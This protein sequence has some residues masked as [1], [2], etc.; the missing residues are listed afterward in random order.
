MRFVPSPEQQAIIDHG[1]EPLRVTAG[2][3]TGKTTTLAYR[4]VRL[5]EH[6][7]ILPGEVLGVTFTN[8]AAD[9]LAQRIRQARAGPFAPGHEVEVFTYHGF[10]AHLLGTYG[11]LVG[12]ERDTRIITPTRTRQI[13]RECLADNPFATVDITNI[14]GVVDSLIRL[15]GDLA[16]N[17][18]HP[19]DLL[20]LP[21][22]DEVEMRRAELATAL[23]AFEEA[24]LELG[25][26]DYGD[27]I[28][29][30]VE[31][32]RDHPAVAERI[33]NRYR[34][35]LLDEYQDTN[36][37]QQ[38]LFAAL[39]GRHGS[40]TAVGDLDQ[41]IYEWRG[42]SPA[43]FEGFPARF[44][45]TDGSRAR[46]LRLS[47]N[48]RSGQRIL[49]L[50]NRIRTRISAGSR[51]GR[52][53]ALPGTPPGE[54]HAA[55]YGDARHEAEEIAR[56]L[57]RLHETGVEWSD[58]A[59][60]FRRNR[61]M[62]L[63][64]QALEEHDVPLQVA[65]L[66]GLLQVPEIVELHAWLRLLADPEDSPALVRILLG[67]RYRL[68]LA[69]LV[70]LSRWVTDRTRR[71]GEP[72]SGH[73]FVE[74]LEHLDSMDLDVGTRNA[75]DGIRHLY[76]TL[77]A[78]SQGTGLSELTRMILSRTS[79]WQEI[80]SMP[81][82]SDLSARLNVHRFLD[83]TE[84]WQPLKGRSS[85]EAFLE[86]MEMLRDDPG[87]QI[88]TARI[89]DGDA[90]TLMTVH[91]AKGLEWRAVF[92]PALFRGNFPASPRRLLDPSRYEFTVPA[93]LRI[94][95]EFRA[96]LDPSTEPEARSAW[97]RARHTDQEWRLA[98]VAC[99]RAMEY[100][101]LSGAH[102]YGVPQVRKKPSQ[103]GEL[104][105][106]ASRLD[107]VVTDEW[108]SEPPPR[109]ERLRFPPSQPG[110]DPVL[111]VSWEEALHN[112]AGD[113]EWAERRAED[114]GIR[115]LYDGAVEEFEQT[116]LDLPDSGEPDSVPDQTA[117]SVTGLV[118]Y[119][120]CPK[121]YY[122]TAVDRLPRRPGPAARRGTLLH[123]RIEL[124][125]RGMIPFDDLDDELYDR[126]PDE[127]STGRGV[128]EGSWH[129]FVESPYATRT[130]I[131]V[132]VPFE[133]R[134]APDIR[135]RGRVD[136]V[137]PHGDHGWEIVDFKSGRRPGRGSNNVQLQAYAVAAQNGGLGAS[138]PESMSVS[139]VYLGDGL[140]VVGQEVDAA[141]LQKATDRILELVGS[142]Q[143]E[144]FDPEPSPACG[145][146]D[147]RHVCP[148]G[149]EWLA[150][151]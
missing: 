5:E 44:R 99:T 11:A 25:V 67:S 39:F 33:R 8:K 47:Y 116:L 70:P 59:V 128:T 76:R 101:Y 57:S 111:G 12:F 17:L 139:F 149:T 113:P 125:N 117:V 42:A 24:K 75:L 14:A 40:V 151:G 55:R 129:A 98:Y 22:E 9:E 84:H 127:S 135:I 141:W 95:A 69:G 45:R 148:E 26:R 118:T 114:L 73:T 16:D 92:L 29:L 31:L 74:A 53:T 121:R 134:L 15:S 119:A 20:A 2:A 4:V 63:V 150:S 62:E 13:L 147:F 97:L 104:L 27:L 21:A 109:P 58:M 140:E 51:S 64:R 72:A 68:G 87:E 34:C 133:L 48:R 138:A 30:A 19:A 126:S 85:L 49:D 103:A 96:N 93:H 132:E 10:A 120:T 86:Q 32:V 146:C 130:P 6:Y 88:D 78:E 65:D 145:T 82:P 144:Q 80:D 100:L 131:Y 110:P 94:D 50:A 124:H 122:W 1:L 28:R 71:A 90:V 81:S 54:V 77:L 61:D 23:V 41:T 43:N 107:G 112:V 3:G 143:A 91:R 36:P 83:F 35:V 142:I 18:A 89:G 38:E 7:G 60:L 102:W 37:A 56:E 46:T 66:G 52:L 79:A 105:E 136:A 108:T 137:Y 106:L 115:G 123:R